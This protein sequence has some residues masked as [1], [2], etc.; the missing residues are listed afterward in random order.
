MDSPHARL[1]CARLAAALQ[2]GGLFVAVLKA[3]SSL[4]VLSCVFLPIAST[5]AEPGRQHGIAGFTLAS[6]SETAPFLIET[7]TDHAIARA[8]DDVR[9]DIERV[10]GVS[11]KLL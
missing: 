7:G 2:G 8:A 5:N 9:G 1:A 6:S 11:P 3:I 10:S 4:T